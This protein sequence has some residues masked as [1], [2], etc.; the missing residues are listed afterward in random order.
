MCI[1]LSLS[2]LL[3][4]HFTYTGQYVRLLRRHNNRGDVPTPFLLVGDM[5]LD[6]VNVDTTMEDGC[7]FNLPDMPVMNGS[8]NS[9]PIGDDDLSIELPSTPTPTVA[10]LTAL[11]YLPIPLLVLSAQKTVV[12]A[13]EAMGRLLGIE[14]ESTATQGLSVTDT[15]CG[16]GIAELGVDILQNGSP[17]MMPWEVCACVLMIRMVFADGNVG[18]P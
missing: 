10:A 16:K 13:N 14:W 2:L 1:S 18:I 4:S 17:L 9:M 11:Q 6:M 15:L 3:H 12:L 8:P 7:Y 5:G